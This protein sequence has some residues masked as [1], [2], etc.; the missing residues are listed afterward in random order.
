MTAEG[1][2]NL[3]G[4]DAELEAIHRELASVSRGAAPATVLLVGEPGIGKTALI[5]AVVAGSDGAL[6]VPLSGFEP[7]RRT[8]LGAAADLLR[9]LRTAG[10][11]GAALDGLLQHGGPEEGPLAPVRVFEAARA[12]LFA[13]APAILLFDDV[14]WADDTS[15][16]LCR[17]VVRAAAGDG[18]PLGFV[19][20]TRPGPHLAA[21]RRALEESADT[22]VHLQLGPID[23]DAGVAL[24][25]SKDPRLTAEDGVRL[26]D[27]AAGSPFWIEALVRRAESPAF[28]T[29]VIMHRLQSLYGDPAECLA[30]VVVAARPISISD[31]A[32]L[33][34][35]PHPRAESAVTALLDRGLIVVAGPSVQVVH[36]LV[37]ETAYRQ[38]PVPER[39]RLHRRVGGWLEAVAGDDLQLLAEALEHQVAAG[40]P[41]LRLVRRLA[42]SPMRRLLGVSGLSRLRSILE[43]APTA[44]PV[45]TELQVELARLAGE[46]GERALAYDMFIVLADRIDGPHERARVLFDAARQAI[47]LERPTDAAALIERARATLPDDP[48]LDVEATALDHARRVWVDRDLTGGRAAVEIAV[49]DARRLVGDAGGIEALGPDARR[50][51]VEVLSAAWDVALTDDNASD[52]VTAAEERV[53]ATRGLGEEHLIAAADAARTLWWSGSFQDAAVKLVAVLDAARGQ[54]YPALVADLC[55][56]L[57]FNRYVLGQLDAALVLLDEADRIEERI[58][59]TTRRSV[60]WLH[61]GLIHVIDASRGEWRRAVA[62]LQALAATYANPHARLRLHQWAGLVAARFG[63][64]SES[65]L[66]RAEIDASLADARTAGCRRCHWDVVLSSAV[67]LARIGAVDSAES[68]LHDWDEAHPTSHGRFAVQREWAR[69]LVAAAPG[70]GAG[71]RELARAADLAA[72]REQRLDEVWIRIDLGRAEAQ[73]DADAAIATWISAARIADAVGAA[74]ELNVIQRELRA[75]G[76]RPLTRRVSPDG[77][78]GLG[79]TPREHEVASMVAL[80]RRNA[81]IAAALFLSPKTVERHLSSIYTKLAVRSRAELA[82]RY[83]SQLLGGAST[84]PT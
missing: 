30:L 15:L 51:Y 64:A 59:A 63:G 19:F 1:G 25:R 69:A 21:L 62:S 35:W 49:A 4:R 6:R 78:A 38:I 9:V 56:V 20:A 43:R 8:P 29:D 71:L 5:R 65:R 32:E 83:G 2:R 14:Q 45:V 57:A 33:L 24:A 79:L 68:L 17:Y 66:V 10:R 70:H 31:V 74:T 13:L 11:E 50:A 12:A 18:V 7:A 23:R 34:G 46:L 53:A 16:E 81:E 37:R 72:R 42:T 80:G 52:M 3:L 27:A 41:S 26:Y 67:S 58:G 77:A 39:H 84:A 60:P 75:V 48:W 82:A 76:A 47:D 55:H 28:E 61:G 22:L 44:D 73:V 54:V 36:D 40:V